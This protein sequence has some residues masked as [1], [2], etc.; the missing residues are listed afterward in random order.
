MLRTVWTTVDRRRRFYLIS[1]TCDFVEPVRL[2]LDHL[3]ALEKSPHAGEL[4]VSLCLCGFFSRLSR[5]LRRLALL[6]VLYEA[7][8]SNERSNQ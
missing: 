8:F 4:F 2:Y 1:E 3:A 7:F 5:R 6:L